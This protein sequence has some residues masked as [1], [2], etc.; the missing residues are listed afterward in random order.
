[1]SGAFFSYN[2]ISLLKR[3]LMTDAVVRDFNV[4][5]QCCGNIKIDRS[6]FER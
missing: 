6:V 3:L 4:K 1:M 2:D 5:Q